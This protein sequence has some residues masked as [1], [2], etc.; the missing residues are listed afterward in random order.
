M[1]LN[2]HKR[3]DNSEMIDVNEVLKRQLRELGV[4]VEVIGEE[5]ETA[6]AEE[7]GGTS[8]MNFDAPTELHRRF[9]AACGVRG[10]SM[11]AIIRALMEAF[12]TATESGRTCHIKV[13]PP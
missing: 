2:V 11:S 3:G 9:K 7:V 6:D 5:L 8:R 13:D 4:T 12:A 1:N 10:A